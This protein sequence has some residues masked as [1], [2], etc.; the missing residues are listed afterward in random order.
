MQRLTTQIMGHAGQLPRERRFR[1]R[2]S[3]IWEIVPQ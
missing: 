2:S 3:C 1:Q